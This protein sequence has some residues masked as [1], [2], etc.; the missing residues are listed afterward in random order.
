VRVILDTNL[1]VSALVNRGTPPDQLYE[2]RRPGRLA[3]GKSH[4]LVL[5]R[6]GTTQILAARELI[7]HL[8]G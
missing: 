7:K 4:L 3:G 8:D 1:L 6:H 2:E 5:G